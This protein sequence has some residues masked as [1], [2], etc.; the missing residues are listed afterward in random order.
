MQILT[1][2]YFD[3]EIVLLLFCFIMRNF[4]CLKHF[5]L[6]QTICGSPFRKKQ[7][8]S[9][10]RNQPILKILYSFMQVFPL[11]EQRRFS[12]FK[13]LCASLP[14]S[15]LFPVYIYV[16]RAGTVSLKG[17]KFPAFGLK[18]AQL[19]LNTFVCAL[20]DWEKSN[21]HQGKLFSWQIQKIIAKKYFFFTFCMLIGQSDWH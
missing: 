10:D 9:K 4:W 17:L 8:L 16:S 3:I 12:G 18:L 19:F 14:C 2:D 5:G 15:K 20:K 1:G 21:S 13:S 11:L 7:G 6:W